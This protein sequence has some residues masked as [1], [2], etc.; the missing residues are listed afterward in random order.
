MARRTVS[1]SIEAD[2]DYPQIIKRIASRE[3]TT[4]GA[5]VRE[6]IDHSTKWSGKIEQER[7]ALFFADSDTRKFQLNNSEP[8]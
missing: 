7:A 2:P 5:I 6:C 8:E 1:I 4:V 3:R